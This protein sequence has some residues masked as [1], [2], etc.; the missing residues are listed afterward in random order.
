MRP[1][2]YHRV[3][4]GRDRANDAA[5]TTKRADGRTAGS[6]VRSRAKPVELMLEV[7]VGT[8]MGLAILALRALLHQQ[9]PA[10]RLV[11]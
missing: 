1:A 8:T 7:M 2:G 4:L 9:S 11:S 6:P 3:D 10:E 5:E